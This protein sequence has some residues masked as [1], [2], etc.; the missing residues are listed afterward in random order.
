MDHLSWAIL[1]FVIFVSGL[2]NVVSECPEGNKCIPLSQCNPQYM[3]SILFPCH[4]GLNLYCCP[5]KG[6]KNETIANVIN[7]RKQIFPE[8]CG[9]VAIDNKITGKLV[10]MNPS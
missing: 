7:R 9:V 3:S 6:V 2:S 10:K 5:S 8:H 4:S 1:V